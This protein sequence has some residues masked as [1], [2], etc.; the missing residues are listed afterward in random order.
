M[1]ERIR[2]G[3]H[4]T[5]TLPADVEDLIQEQRQR[6]K[7]STGYKPPRGIVIAEAIRAYYGHSAAP[8]DVSARK[9]A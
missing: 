7:Q 8:G 9:R 1:G 6:L 4:V 3:H 2:I 5:L